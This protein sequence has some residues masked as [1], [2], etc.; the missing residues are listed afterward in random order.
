PRSHPDDAVYAVMEALLW[1]NADISRFSR[2]GPN[3]LVES[4]GGTNGTPGT[5]YP[6]L[7]AIHA[8]PAAGKT[9]AVAVRALR[10]ELRR[11]LPNPAPAEELAVVVRR[12]RAYLLLALGTDEGTAKLLAEAHARHGDWREAFRKIDRLARVT[13]ADVLRVARATFV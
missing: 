1:G 2:L 9:L 12:A 3:G 13:P 5:K 7:F 8:T 6:S 11:L 10:T 4:V